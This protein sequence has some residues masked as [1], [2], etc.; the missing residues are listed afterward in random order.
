MK[1]GIKLLSNSV[2][3]NQLD[4]V[5]QW[6]I[7]KG[8]TASFYFQLIDEERGHRY[9]PA[10]GATLAYRISRFPQYFPTNA[11]QRETRD[12]TISG[13]ASNP[14]PKDTSIFKF[15]LTADQTVTLTSS[16]V[17][18]TL[19]EGGNIKN[20]QVSQA[21]SAKNNEEV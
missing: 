10:D 9:I 1:L 11:N 4:T 6:K 20:V 21:I 19:T 12:Y 14:F 15:D 3:V 18:F 5:N 8:D 17:R 13:F 2:T 16:A 7:Q